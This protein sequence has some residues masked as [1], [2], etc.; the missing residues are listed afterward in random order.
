MKHNN[1]YLWFVLKYIYRTKIPI[2]Q[3]LYENNIY[4][5][6]NGLKIMS[7]IKSKSYC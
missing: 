5:P 1:K 7:F 4:F 3:K 2:K 6:K